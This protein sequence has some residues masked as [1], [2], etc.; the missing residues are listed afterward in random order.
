MG[1]LRAV[2][3][4]GCALIV[5]AVPALG[6]QA[7][8]PDAALD[9]LL[10]EARAECAQ[11][12]D[13]LVRALCGGH[14][15]IGV[16]EYYP[17]F[18]TREGGVRQGY[19]VDVAKAIGKRLGVDVDFTRVNAA[20][21]IPLIADDRIDLVIAT[22]GHNT[23]RDG[24]VR[25]IRPHYY[26]S[27][28]TV[29][30]PRAA[31]IADQTDL[32]G[33]TVCVTIGNGSN[34]ELVSF[35][36]RLMLFD[37]AGVLPDRLMD[38]TCTLA[39]Q[40][41]SFFAYYFTDSAFNERFFQKFGFSQVP[42]GMAVARQGSDRLARALDLMSQIF[43]R[44]GV[45]LGIAH[46][47][48][49]GTGFLEHQK[50]VWNGPQCNTSTGSTNPACV[51]APL[52]AELAPTSFAGG[53]KAFEA[54][55]ERHADIELSLPMLTTASAWSMF[56]EGVINSLILIAGA[57][58]AT[59][60]FALL[61]GAAMA[62]HSAMLRWP[63]RAVTVVLQ[64]SPIVLTLVIAAAIAR[65]LFPF[66][67][68]VALGASIAALGLSNG[69]N[70]GQAISEA[71]VSLEHE[72]GAGAFGWPTRFGRALSR[73]ATQI[74]A[75]LVNA[76][77]GSPIA[78]FIGAPELLSAL[79]DITSFSSG[80]VTTYTLLLVFYVAVVMVVVWLCGLFRQFLEHRQAV[81]PT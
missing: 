8:T 69:S 22:M 45:F 26:Q 47:H 68:A 75:F 1:A 59:L 28:T 20:S 2:L 80:R 10:E 23:Q 48:R 76:A 72:H 56:K 35:G 66:S 36:A 67:D 70:A 30:G 63:A 4:L 13:R 46:A 32:P 24:Q 55:V 7:G 41:D 42:W 77:K 39:A 81:V 40:D 11:P 37:E 51:L 79:T 19:E 14:I 33:R 54:W 34:A 21:R 18:A 78:S 16:R 15:R 49:I 52:S 60:A 73:S 62:A 53:V 57:L 65:A 44:D 29:V 64:S 6:Q 12:A 27:E 3:A 74:V 17:L 43:H 31:L 71:M 25:F 5:F 9:Q 58:A 50:T 38:G 61:F